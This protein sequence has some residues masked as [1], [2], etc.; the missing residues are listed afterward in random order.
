MT[1]TTKQQI[2]IERSIHTW[3]VITPSGVRYF[4]KKEIAEDLVRCIEKQNKK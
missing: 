1:T 3:N 4:R 2:R